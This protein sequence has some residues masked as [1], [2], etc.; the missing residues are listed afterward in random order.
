MMFRRSALT[1]DRAE[2]LP[3]FSPL[4]GTGRNVSATRCWSHRPKF[5]GFPHS[6]QVVF[7]EGSERNGRSGD[8]H[9]TVHEIHAGCFTNTKTQQ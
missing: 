1:R 3:S 8:P 5:R 9:K 7:L 2:Y 6:D 4:K